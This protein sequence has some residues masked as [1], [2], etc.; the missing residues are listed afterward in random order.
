MIISEEIFILR[1]YIAYSSSGFALPVYAPT[2][3][4]Y[5]Y[6][7][8]YADFLNEGDAKIDEFAPI[9][10]NFEDKICYIPPDQSIQKSVGDP[11]TNIF[12]VEGEF[13]V[14][15]MRDI[16]EHLRARPK[17]EKLKFPISYNRLAKNFGSQKEKDAAIKIESD[18]KFKNSR[19][20][21]L[22]IARKRRHSPNQATKGREPKRP[23]PKTEFQS[24]SKFGPALTA[25]EKIVALQ[26]GVPE[27]PLR[28]VL[29][30]LGAAHIPAAEIP[31][32]LASA[33]DELVALRA[34]LAR[35]PNDDRP[36]FRAIREAAQVHI[37]AGEFDKARAALQSGR[38]AARDLRRQADRA[39]AQFLSAEARVDLLEQRSVAA[40]DKFAEAANLNPDDCWLWF[41]LGD[42]WID[43][44]NS[45]EALAAYQQGKAAAERSGDDRDLS[46]SH[47]KI[48]DVLV[49][50]G[51]LPDALAAFRASHDIF[52][53]LAKDD[54]QNAVW[55][56]DL[57]VSQDTT[58]DVLVAH[59][60]LTQALD[61]FR[62]SLDIRERL[63][64]DDPQN[65]GWQRD[66]SVSH[67]KMGD[68]LV[69]QGNLTG[70]L[71]AFRA[72]LDIA[73][74]LA[75]A[76]PQNAEWQRDLSVSQDRIGNVRVAQGNLTGALAS[77]RASL[78]IRERLAKAD[79]QNAGW[80]RD[81]SVSHNK[82]G[83]V[84]VAQG[85]LTD[86]LAA[87]RA[88]HDIFERLAKADPQNAGWQRDLAISHF[89]T[90]LAEEQGGDIQAAIES[91]EAGRTVLAALV[92]R[93]PDVVQWHQDLADSERDLTRLRAA[94]G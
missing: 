80:Q 22:K 54:P 88:S 41:E 44:G 26:A 11:W 19:S 30:R 57:S 12:L 46:V 52:E 53:R 35:M 65:A 74:R 6:F 10:G 51:N 67:N 40:R 3:D 61:V 79:P 16:W 32:A 84:L 25:L 75:K 85:N 86:A 2:S 37:D 13:T 70:A 29:E 62:A 58:G 81:L 66:L 68:V 72:S 48:G 27:A 36:E 20:G 18:W 63:A 39:E 82:I 77:F 4:Q 14:G 38:E 8:A 93:M 49:A 9:E 56:R 91:F 45:N 43:T 21:S 5:R 47:N 24:E 64:K 55:Q 28:K 92:E 42:L 76:D 89:K 59:G 71:A 90:G 87:F 78:D 94:R 33:A 15:S 23:K 34:Q 60:N 1:G 73:G 31:A 17:N 83:T 50:Q 69:A 7:I